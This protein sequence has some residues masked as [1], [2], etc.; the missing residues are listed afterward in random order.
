VGF[1]LRLSIVTFL[2]VIYLG[3]AAAFATAAPIPLKHFAN[4]PDVSNVTLSPNGNKIVSKI[5][6]DVGDRQ[7]IAVQ[8]QDLVTKEKKMLLFTDNTKYFISSIWW[9]DDTTLLVRTWYPS[10]RD[11]WTGFSQARFKT[12]ETRLLIINTETGEV[13]SPYTTAYLKQFTILPVNL[14]NVIS[15]LPNDPDH[16]L[17]SSASSG[18]SKLPDR[19]QNQHKKSFKNVG[20]AQ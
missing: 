14:S 17:M 3:L 20:P 5:R 2:S 19:T 6:I 13:T 8:S 4:L 11:T 15:S 10:E 9:K 12:R 16:I 1:S 7:G 18:G